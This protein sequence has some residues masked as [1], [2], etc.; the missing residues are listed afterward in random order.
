MNLYFQLLE[1]EFLA[2]GTIEKSGLSVA[3]GLIDSETNTIDSLD[4]LVTLKKVDET[5]FQG[6]F[7][8]R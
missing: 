7:T 5:S 4:R 6:F 1:R 2:T 8:T 3:T